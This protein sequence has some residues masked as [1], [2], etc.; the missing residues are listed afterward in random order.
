MSLTVGGTP[1]A[2]G[3]NGQ[4]STPPARLGPLT[5]AA[6]ASDAAGNPGTATATLSVIDPTDTSAPTVSIATPANMAAITSP[7]EVV[8]TVSDSHILSWTLAE[9]PLNSNA[10]TTIATGT[11]TVANADLGLFDPTTL[12]DGAYT[13]RL[14]AWNAGGH[15]NSTSITVNVSGYLKL[16]NLTCRSPT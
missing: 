11:S 9:A 8:G 2:L 16:G 7:T 1:V 14:T 10:F 15:V 6:T 12:A 3:D 5:V 13:L 4:G